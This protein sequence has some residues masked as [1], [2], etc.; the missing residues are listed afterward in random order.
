MRNGWLNDFG[1]RGLS[2]FCDDASGFVS[3]W[4]T[5]FYFLTDWKESGVP[6]LAYDVHSWTLAACRYATFLHAIRKKTGKNESQLYIRWS[7]WTVTLFVQWKFQFSSE[8][9]TVLDTNDSYFQEIPNQ[10]SSIHRFLNSNKLSY[11]DIPIRLNQP[12]IAGIVIQKR[13]I[14][15]DSE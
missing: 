15:C 5:Y 14:L 6:V 3:R 10:V 9:C 1:I 2:S 13:G 7:K 4:G 8:S 12:I 11:F